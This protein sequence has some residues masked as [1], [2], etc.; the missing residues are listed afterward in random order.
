[1]SRCSEK[2]AARVR[3]TAFLSNMAWLPSKTLPHCQASSHIPTAAKVRS[4][5]LRTCFL[6]GVFFVPGMSLLDLSFCSPPQALGPPWIFPQ[7][8][9]FPFLKRWPPEGDIDLF[10]FRCLLSRPRSVFGGKISP[11][12]NASAWL[13]QSL[14]L[15]QRRHP[16]VKPQSTPETQSVQMVLSEL[17]RKPR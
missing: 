13:P 11:L 12:M 9:Y 1:M 8:G 7:A 15:G 16:E 6:L 10:F 3:F 5:S 17:D 14:P 2:V 4:L